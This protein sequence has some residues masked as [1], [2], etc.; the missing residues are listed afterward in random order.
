LPSAASFPGPAG[1]NTKTPSRREK[2]RAE[3]ETAVK[4]SMMFFFIFLFSI[5]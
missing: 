3:R 1:I 5:P 2:S 4:S